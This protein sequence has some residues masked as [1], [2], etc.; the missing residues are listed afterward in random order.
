[1]Y[2]IKV[3]SLCAV[4]VLGTFLPARRA[5][6]TDPAGNWATNPP[7]LKVEVKFMGGPGLVPVNR[8]FVTCG[9]NKFTFLMPEGFRLD[10]SD[11]QKVTLVS[12]DYNCLLTW[13]VQGPMSPEGTAFDHALYRNVLLSRHPGGKILEE[14]SLGALGRYGPAFD[15]RWGT[16]GGLARRERIMFI[17]SLAGVVEFSLVSSLEKF[18]AGK[19]AFDAWR[20]SFRASDANGKL[21]VPMMSNKF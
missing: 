16:S 7:P 15:L 5:A 8:A 19:Q 14:F 18:E 4:T 3:I 13:R 20:L 1:M 17:E 12:T 6:A 2:A 21:V 11:R 10:T 9:T